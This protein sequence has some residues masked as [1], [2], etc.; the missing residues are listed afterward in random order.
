V[1]ACAEFAF[2]GTGR[3][4]ALSRKEVIDVTVAARESGGRPAPAQPPAALGLL[5]GLFN[6]MTTW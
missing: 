5:A 2:D 1:A 6:N 3:A 4:L